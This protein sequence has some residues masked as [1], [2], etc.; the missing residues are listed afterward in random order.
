[1]TLVALLSVKGKG[2]DQ[3]AKEISI[4]FAD[5]TTGKATGNVAHLFLGARR[6]K[7]LIHGDT[8]TH[9]A[10]GRRICDLRHYAILNYRSNHRR[11]KRADARL[12][13]RDLEERVGLDKAWQVIDAA[14]VINP[15]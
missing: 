5:G 6:I 7:T 4:A 1:M 10:S 14:P 8:L 13:L 3:M 9:Y 11:D 2:L 15:K 12:A